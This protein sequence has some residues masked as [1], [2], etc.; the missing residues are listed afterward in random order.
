MADKP[1][2]TVIYQEPTPAYKPSCLETGLS[3]VFIIVF[4]TMFG[5]KFWR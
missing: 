2:V 4:L 1:N 3:V 5:V